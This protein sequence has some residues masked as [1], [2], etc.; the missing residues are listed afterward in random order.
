MYIGIPI[1]TIANFKK[2]K[3]ISEDFD[4][5]VAALKEGDSELIEVNEENQVRR[6]TKVEEQDHASR[7]I[8][9]K[10]FE[11]EKATED[12]IADL[13]NLQDDIQEFFEQFGTVLCVRMRKEQKPKGEFKGSVFVEFSTPEEAEKVAA[14][15]LEYKGKKLELLT[16][17]AY[18]EKK[19]EQYKGK[20][21]PQYKKFGFNAFRV[22]GNEHR[23][24]RKQPFKHNDKK[25]TNDDKKTGEKRELE[26]GD[27][28]NENKD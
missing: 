21:K 24:N 25:S 17:K 9:A 5:V 1:S 8:Y 7:S 23:S 10:A 20:E 12:N 19:A 16:K 27:D 14:M 3:M 18:V 11:V 2:M 4:T 6:K 28:E 26:T 15:D 22:H 13:L